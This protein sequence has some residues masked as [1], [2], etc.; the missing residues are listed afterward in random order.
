MQINFPVFNEESRVL[1]IALNSRNSLRK[2]Q[3]FQIL[4]RVE[5]LQIPGPQIFSPSNSTLEKYLRWNL[6]LSAA[7]IPCLFLS[8][9]GTSQNFPPRVRNSIISK[10]KS[11][12]NTSRE[13]QFRVLIRAIARRQEERSLA[14]I[15]SRM[16][17]PRPVPLEGFR[18]ATRAPAMINDVDL[19][20]HHHFSRID[21]CRWYSLWPERAL[22]RGKTSARYEYDVQSLERPT[23]TTNNF[24]SAKDETGCR[25]RARKKYSLRVEMGDCIGIEKSFKFPRFR[26][27][28]G[29]CLERERNES[30]RFGKY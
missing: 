13:R 10:R 16:I 7:S 25:D 24:I 11:R 6:S 30:P 23:A 9:L 19:I 22:T 3:N 5:V 27:T 15:K 29:Y 20:Y 12:G 18:G 28:S 26:Y 1:A 4:K 2:T 8:N 17:F 21:G 14:R